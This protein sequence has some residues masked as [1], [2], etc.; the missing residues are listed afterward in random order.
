VLL[1]EIIDRRSKLP[2]EVLLKTLVDAATRGGCLTD[3]Q[4]EALQASR[5]RSLSET[6]AGQ[7][8]SDQQRTKIIDQFLARL[9]A[10]PAPAID[11]T[12]VEITP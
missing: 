3:D 5:L 11:V 7:Y 12:D 9:G 1:Q 4:V 6:L 2:T 8:L 10:D